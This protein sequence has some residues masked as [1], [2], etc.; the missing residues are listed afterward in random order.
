MK[1]PA[2]VTRAAEQFGSQ[3]VVVAIDAKHSDGSWQVYTAG[4]RTPTGLDA[5]EWAK[6]AE[7]RGAGEILLTSMDRDGTRDGYD[8]ELLKRV[9]TAVGI[10]VIASGGAGEARHL[11]EAVLEGK[12]DAV[13][14]AGIVHD[15]T[16]TIDQLKQEMKRNR[17]PVRELVP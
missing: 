13:L 17:I 3:C 11:V 9:S 1:D 10:P 6:E 16:T 8:L 12:A 7:Q 5:I 14:V 15:G 4:G 2:L